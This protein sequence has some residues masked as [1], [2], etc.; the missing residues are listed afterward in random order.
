MEENAKY[1]K[2]ELQCLLIVLS[3]RKTSHVEGLPVIS[4]LEASPNANIHSYRYTD[5]QN[6]FDKSRFPFLASIW[7]HTADDH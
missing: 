3:D 7:I 5:V 2:F 6:Y 4:Q 1:D